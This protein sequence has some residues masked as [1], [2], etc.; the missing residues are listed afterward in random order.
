MNSQWTE[1]LYM[2]V[3]Y[4]RSRV[5]TFHCAHRASILRSKIDARPWAISIN[6]AGCD[7]EKVFLDFLHLARAQYTSL[8]GLNEAFW[9][10]FERITAHH[11]RLLVAR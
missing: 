5:F 2:H 11:S 4:V 6:P 1:I 3:I 9:W 8:Q 10:C 7:R